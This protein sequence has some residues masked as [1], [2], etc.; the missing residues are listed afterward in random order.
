MEN[1]II[2]KIDVI[3]RAIEAILLGNLIVANAVVVRIRVAE[4]V[5]AIIAQAIEKFLFLAHN[6]LIFGKGNK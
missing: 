1:V 3:F 2:E 5:E 4:S 6:I